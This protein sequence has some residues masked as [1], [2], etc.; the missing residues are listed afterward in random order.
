MVP[1]VELETVP[2]VESETVPVV[3]PELV[4]AVEV[5]GNRHSFHDP[6]IYDKPRLLFDVDSYSW[7]KGYI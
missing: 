4:L 5:V 7:C 3:E 2:V 1:V 6:G